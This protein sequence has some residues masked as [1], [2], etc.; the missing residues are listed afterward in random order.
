MSELNLWLQQELI[1][2]SPSSPSARKYIPRRLQAYPFVNTV[3][4][5]IPVILYSR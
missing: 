3:K 1:C 5:D 4:S 2:S